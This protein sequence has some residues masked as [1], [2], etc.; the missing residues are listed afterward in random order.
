MLLAPCWLARALAGELPAEGS[1]GAFLGE[2]RFAMQP[3]YAKDRFPNLVVALDGTVLAFFNGVKVRRSGDGGATWGEEV[4]VGRGFMGGGVTVDETTGE[5]LAFV[6]EKHP[7]A[8]LTVYGSKDQGQTWQPRETVI[9]GNQAGNVPAMHMNE[10]GV[11][12]RFGPHRGRLLRPSRWYAQANYP[13][14]NFPTHYTDAIYSDDGGR[15]WQASEPF[16]KMGTGEATLAELSDGRIYYN[17]RRH[18]APKGENPR[19]RWTAWSHDGGATWTN[20]VM[21]EVL[22]DGDQDRDYGLMGGLVRLPVAG[23]DILVFSNIESPAG[24]KGGTVWASFDGGTTWPLKRRI[25]EG[26]FGYSSVNAGRPGTPSEGW[27]YV[28]FENGGAG[29]SV[30]RFNLRWL[31]AGERT[32]DGAVPR[33]AAGDA[34]APSTPPASTPA[35]L[36]RDPVYD[37]AADPV[38]VWNPARESWWMLYTQRRAKLDLP[39][40]AWCHGC[41][42]GVAESQD[43]GLSWSY[44]GQLP[45]SHPDPGYSFWAPDVVRDESGTFHLFVTYVPGDGDRKIDW[46]GDRYLFQYRSADLWTWDFVQRIPA[47]SDRCIDPTVFRRPD[48]TWR[49]WYK[50]EGRRSET[51]ALDSRDLRT[52]TPA[53]DPGVSRLYGEAPKVFSLGG[54]YWMLKD[55]DSGLDVY[56]STNLSTWTYQGK[57]LDIPGRRNDDGSIGKH[58]DVVVAGERGCIIYF[59]HPHGQRFPS[60]DNKMPLAAKR[61][62]LQAAELE[63]RD[64]RLVVDRDRPFRIQ[65]PT[66]PATAAAGVP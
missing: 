22:P 49:L 25:A 64:G 13:P 10:H 59:T 57:I 18:W 24:R 31:L 58:P 12:L 26:G 35:P 60:V 33:W 61:S 43:A 4:L 50:D 45:L 63:V 65:L 39:G 56:C 55:P 5:I 48:G 32:G 23:R 7:P 66:P 17:T 15:T 37:G 52:W 9:K 20:A 19:R 34:S 38:L 46:A 62:S 51:L 42:I 53:S 1:L 36:Y 41:E 8:P 16:P 29:A 3:V 28:M 21:S 47:T 2:P 30:A 54:A 40:V 14:E 11:T 44:L 27:V 6:E